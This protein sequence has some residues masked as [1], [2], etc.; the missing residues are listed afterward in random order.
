VATV[1]GVAE[2]QARL[3]AQLNQ[4]RRIVLEELMRYA[5][6]IEQYMKT[7]HPWRNQTGEAERQ[8]KALV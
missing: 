1:T 4:L 8:L 5:P 6:A 3:D 7:N 2:T